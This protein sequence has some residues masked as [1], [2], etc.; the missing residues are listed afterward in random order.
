LEERLLPD[1]AADV[2]AKFVV[3]PALFGSGKPVCRCPVPS[4]KLS[5]IN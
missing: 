4:E 2:I 3:D 5:G 1:D